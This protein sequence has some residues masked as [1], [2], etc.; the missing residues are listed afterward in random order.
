MLYTF[1]SISS[2]ISGGISLSRDMAEAWLLSD[3]LKFY[4]DDSLFEC[5]VGSGVFFEELDFKASFALG[6]FATVFQAEVYAILA[7][8]DYC[9]REC[10]SG[11]RICICSDSQVALLA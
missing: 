1:G 6:T 3:S 10:M 5:R 2:E 9:L 11:K 7:C 4:N 8:S